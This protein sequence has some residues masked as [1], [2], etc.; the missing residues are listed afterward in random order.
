MTPQRVISIALA[1][2][3][4]SAPFIALLYGRQPGLIVLA[5]TL[6]ATIGIGLSMRQ[7]IPPERQQQLNL[8]L[9]LN[10]AL[11]ALAIIG[12]MLTL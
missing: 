6:A 1:V 11:L 8:M 2:A 10:A 5:A 4:L 9:A 3:M 7:T 12:V